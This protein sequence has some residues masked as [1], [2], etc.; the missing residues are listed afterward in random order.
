[1]RARELMSHPA[2]TVTPQTPV[3]VAAAVLCEHG[4]TALPVVDGS[5]LAGIVTEAD[6][7]GPGLPAGTHVR[8]V[9]TAPV[10]SLTPDADRD[11]IVRIML[12]ARI[13]CLPV[14]DGLRVVGVVTRRDLLR[15]RPEPAEQVLSEQVSAERVLADQVSIDRGPTGHAST[16]EELADQID[17][18]L[19]TLDTANRWRVSVAGGIADIEDYGTDPALRDRA[20]RIASTVPGVVR[21]H[22]HHQTPDPF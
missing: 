19:A 22:A 1:M 21:V 2:I 17:R 4:F 20:A 12:D 18:Q 11:D 15:A 9:M 6:L 3:G 16:D 8:D 5:E 10:E 14:V 7:L 13:R